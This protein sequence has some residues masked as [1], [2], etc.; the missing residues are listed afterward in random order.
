MISVQL[1][2]TEVY[3][4]SVYKDL[5]AVVGPRLPARRNRILSDAN[6]ARKKGTDQ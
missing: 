6:V 2:R 5:V 4:L 1:T 3:T